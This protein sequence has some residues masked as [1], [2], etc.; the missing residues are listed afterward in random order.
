VQGQEWEQKY[1]GS[2][3]GSGKGRG[4]GGSWRGMTYAIY[5]IFLCCGVM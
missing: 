4:K 2:N 5:D 3:R 1:R